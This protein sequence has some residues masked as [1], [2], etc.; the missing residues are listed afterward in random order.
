MVLQA[1][2]PRYIGIDLGTTYSAMAWLDSHGT[3][4]TLTNAEDDTTTPSV[5]LFEPSGEVIVGREAKRAALMVPDLVADYVKRDM[6]EAQYH[7]RINFRFYSPPSISALILK[8]LKQDA[9]RRIGP[10]TGAVI[11]VPAYFD[12]R[13]RRATAAAGEIAGL[14]IID[15][16]NEPTAA[17]L[18]YAF[19]DFVSNGGKPD[20]AVG[21]AIAT[22]APHIA[23]VYDLGGGTFDVTVLRICGD[24][25]TVLATD[26]DAKLG[27]RE[28]DDCIVDWACRAFKKQYRSDPRKDPHSFQ[29]IT[30]AAEESKKDLSRLPRT[31]IVVTHAGQQLALEL[32]REEF[33]KMTAHLLERT[34]Q[35]VALVIEEAGLIWSQVHEVLAVGGSSR[36][37]M[38]LRMLRDVTGKEPNCS[39]PPGEAVAHGAAIHAAIKAVDL[40]QTKTH[41]SPSLPTPDSPPP[42]PSAR[43]DDAQQDAFSG[44]QPIDDLLP[45][46]QPVH[47]NDDW[48]DHH[49]NSDSVTDETS[50]DALLEAVLSDETID[51]G[52]GGDPSA[53][54]DPA[55]RNTLR[56]V[57]KTDVNA[58]SLGV[59][60]TRSLGGRGKSILIPRNTPL[61]ASA[62]KIYGTM[63][64][65]QPEVVIRILEGESPYVDECTMLGTCRIAD[66]PLDLTKGSPVE[67]TFTLDDSGR[68]NVRAVETTSGQFV[69]TTIQCESGISPEKIDRAREAL[70][71]ISVV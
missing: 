70:E 25:L 60:V 47:V 57:K 7:K 66:L 18:A 9:E 51:L 39:L 13:R 32:A 27:G 37:P 11:T 30:L 29:Q 15:I 65:N 42:L 21:R 55:V 19:R 22:T 62:T 46:A 58:H 24:D 4:V 6:G 33:E 67:V 20:D 59:I 8:K 12:E 68:L 26:G 44:I 43:D 54:F 45:A 41:V 56:R 36:M 1:S 10:I 2:G 3:P 31:R 23:V 16:L 50:R 28:W 5:V 14:R 40:W 49:S 69:T 17:A 35:R 63:K 61:P 38:V 52:M 53:H 64:E 34:R 71:H 48:D